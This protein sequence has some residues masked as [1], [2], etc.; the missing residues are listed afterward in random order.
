MRYKTPAFWS[1]ELVMPAP[2][3]RVAWYFP[4]DGEPQARSLYTAMCVERGVIQDEERKWTIGV[5]LVAWDIHPSH[6]EAV[7]M[8]VDQIG[9][10]QA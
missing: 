2:H 6:D 4:M 9:W 1:V 3:H 5:N 10:N 8:I 7:G